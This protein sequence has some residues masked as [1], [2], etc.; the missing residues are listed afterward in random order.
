MLGFYDALENPRKVSTFNIGDIGAIY[1]EDLRIEWLI[2]SLG[3]EI[4][5]ARFVGDKAIV[6][7]HV[8]NSFKEL[9]SDAFEFINFVR[10]GKLNFRS[11]GG[12]R[13]YTLKPHIDFASVRAIRESQDKSQAQN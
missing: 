11:L 1:I 4:P 12:V 10:R 5:Q 7:I 3:V 8:Q 6:V 2:R 9:S 13:L